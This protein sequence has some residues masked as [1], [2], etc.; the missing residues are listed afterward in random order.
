M[1]PDTEPEECAG[2]FCPCFAPVTHHLEDLDGGGPSVP[3]CDEHWDWTMELEKRLNAEPEFATRFA[4]AIDK[5]LA[6]GEQ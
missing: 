1:K 5:E 6:G 3:L 2:L 4:L